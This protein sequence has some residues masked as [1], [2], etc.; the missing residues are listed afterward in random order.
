MGPTH[1]SPDPPFTSSIRFRAFARLEHDLKDPT[2][3]HIELER[4][5]DSP[6]AP[7]VVDEGLSETPQLVLESYALRIP[8][9]IVEIRQRF[10][11]G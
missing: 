4:A 10:H 2:V 5:P 6:G 9:G 8:L 7:H 3:Y 11:A 1:G